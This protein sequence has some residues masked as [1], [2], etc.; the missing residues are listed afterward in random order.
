MAFSVRSLFDFEGC[1]PDFLS[2]IFKCKNATW[3]KHWR[4]PSIRELHSLFSKRLCL[5][6]LRI[7]SKVDESSTLIL[8][9]CFTCMRWRLIFTIIWVSFHFFYAIL[10]SNVFLNG[11]DSVVLPVGSI[12]NVFILPA[13]CNHDYYYYD[14]DDYNNSSNTSFSTSRLLRKD[15]EFIQRIEPLI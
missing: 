2:Y 11:S 4:S 8:H 3:H 1:L 7:E 15:Q 5:W 14:N 12:F 9:V 6:F 13:K 10:R